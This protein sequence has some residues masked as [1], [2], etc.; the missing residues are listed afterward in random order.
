M[1]NNIVDSYIRIIKVDVGTTSVQSNISIPANSTILR[2]VVKVIDA[3]SNTCTLVGD[4]FIKM[5]VECGNQKNLITNIDLR[6]P[7]IYTNEIYEATQTEN[8]IDVSIIGNNINSGKSIVFV[9]FIGDV[10]DK[11]TSPKQ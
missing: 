1:I 10:I 3:Y 5:N 4:N 7:D 6:C 9:E 2:V 8:K 11:T